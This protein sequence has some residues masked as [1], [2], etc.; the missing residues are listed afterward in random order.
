MVYNF[1]FWK[2][3]NHILYDAVLSWHQEYTSHMIYT[4][5]LFEKNVKY[6][7]EH[8]AR[9][10]YVLI[11]LSCL[12]QNTF[13]INNILITCFLPFSSLRKWK[14][15]SKCRFDDIILFK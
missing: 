15:Y 1:L 14:I 2:L 7:K 10:I 8:G 5:F 4:S 6:S 12:I 13:G 11:I 9:K 3:H